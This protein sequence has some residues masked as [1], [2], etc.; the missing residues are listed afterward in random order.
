MTLRWLGLV[1]ASLVFTSC[2]LVN[3]PIAQRTTQGPLAE[4]MWGY[5]V[6]VQNGRT[7]TY[8]ERQRWDFDISRRVDAYLREHSEVANAPDVTAFRFWRQP[9]VGMTK[10]QVLLLLDAPVQIGRAH[11]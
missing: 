6:T 7:P 10:E 9:T 2:A 11:V 5:R 1:A 4:D 8:E 3:P